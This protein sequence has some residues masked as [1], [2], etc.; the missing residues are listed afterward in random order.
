MRSQITSLF[1]IVVFLLFLSCKDNTEFSPETDEYLPEIINFNIPAAQAYF[2]SQV[3]H[4]IP[5]H[6]T[7]SIPAPTTTG[8]SSSELTPEWSKATRSINPEVSLIEV[9]VSSNTPTIST[10]KNFKEGKNISSQSIINTTRLVVARHKTG[11]TEMFVITLVPISDDSSD[12]SGSIKNF[13][14]PEGGNFTG[15]VF[16]STLEGKLIEVY[17]YTNGKKGDAIK[18]IKRSNLVRKGINP[19]ND[20]YESIRISTR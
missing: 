9:P 13:R 20:S 19:G 10:I 1:K 14:Y 7:D 15:K 12:T 5:L 18:V 2:E 3:R 17:Q 6:F 11:Q 16:C 8:K 4:L